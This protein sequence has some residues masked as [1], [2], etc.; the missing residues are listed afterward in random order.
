MKLDLH[1]LKIFYQLCL[2][3][4][5]TKAAQKLNITQ[6]AVSHSI[7][8]LEGVLDTS[9]ID[10]SARVFCLTKSGQLLLNTC[11]KTF[12]LFEEAEEKLLNGEIETRYDVVIGATVEFGNTVLIEKIAEIRRRLTNFNFELNLHH[13][14]FER[15]QQNEMDLIIDCK[16]HLEE[17]I[18]SIYLCD[19]PYSIIATPEYASKHNLYDLKNFRKALLLSCDKNLDWWERFFSAAPADIITKPERIFTIN[20]IRG[21]INAA[22]Q[23]VGITIVPRYTVLKEL[24]NNILVELFTEVKLRK[25]KFRIYIK[26]EKH[27]LLKNK[28]IIHELINSFKEF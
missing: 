21:L 16:N 3:K 12:P 23:G 7:R 19:E 18:E 9:L 8:K 2:Y 20:H 26:T 11:E 1:Y 10:R 27:K 28:E 13:K 6:S 4:N 24:E 15:L 14:L 22:L 25:D 5:Y 17:N